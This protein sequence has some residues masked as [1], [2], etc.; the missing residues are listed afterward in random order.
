[1]RTFL[2][3]TLQYHGDM[4]SLSFVL[5]QSNQDLLLMPDEQVNLIFLKAFMQKNPEYSFSLDGSPISNEKTESIIANGGEDFKNIEVCRMNNLH[6]LHA[7][8][9]RVLMIQ[10]NQ[11]QIEIYKQ[12]L[13]VY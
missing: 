7:E 13:P 2:L 12:V 4:E 1:M 11:E 5:L 6:F 10:L 3:Q 8:L 9:D